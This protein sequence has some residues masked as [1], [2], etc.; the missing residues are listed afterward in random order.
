MLCDIGCKSNL[1]DGKFTLCANKCHVCAQ[2]FLYKD[3]IVT[4][5]KHMYHPSCI[6]HTMLI[7]MHVARLMIVRKHGIHGDLAIEQ[8][9]FDE[10]DNTI[11]SM[12]V[13]ATK[14]KG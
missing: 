3:V 9:R 10:F 1:S 11:T 4:S 12:H 7:L 2:W 6:K 14:I 8:G 5:C 13:M